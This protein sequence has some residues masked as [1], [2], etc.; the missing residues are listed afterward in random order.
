MIRDRLQ[1]SAMTPSDKQRAVEMMDKASV[2]VMGAN[3]EQ[4]PAARPTVEAVAKE[5]SSLGVT[6]AQGAGFAA[7]SINH[8]R[9]KDARDTA[10]AAEWM[11]EQRTKIAE[12]RQQRMNTA[13][14]YVVSNT[15]ADT[16]RLNERMQTAQRSSGMEL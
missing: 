13:R 1:A 10:R 3:P 16:Q 4:R 2:Y 14:L 7:I 8:T 6:P 11:S 12:A 9:E 5:W 15:T